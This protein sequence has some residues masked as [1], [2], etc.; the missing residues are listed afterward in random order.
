MITFSPLLTSADEKLIPP[1]NDL[2]GLANYARVSESLYR[3]AQPAQQGFKTLKKMGIKTI[4][5]LRC[6]HSDKELLQGTG[7]QYVEIPMTTFHISDKHTAQFLKIILDPT[8][9]PVFVHCEHG[10]DRTGT[11]IAV[12]RM[13]VQ[14][15]DRDQAIKE[16]QNFGFHFWWHNLV[17][18]LK[19]VDFD[20]LKEMLKNVKP[21]VVSIIR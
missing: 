9:Q 11:M 10:S 5:N 13:V 16:M 6:M 21:P 17:I 14:K 20:K 2:P 3:G 7:L 8:N 4:V 18:Y 19:Q 15:W 12:Y 1:A